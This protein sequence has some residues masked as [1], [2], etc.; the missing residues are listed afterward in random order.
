MMER[1]FARR[2]TPLRRHALL[3]AGVAL[4]EGPQARAQPRPPVCIHCGCAPALRGRRV[5]VECAAYLDG[6]VRREVVA[7][8]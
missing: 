5:C 7:G 8:E 4:P 1:T 3:Q 6:V 2:M